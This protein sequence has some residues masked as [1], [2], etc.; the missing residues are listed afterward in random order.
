[1]KPA[2]LTRQR[3]VRAALELFTTKGFHLT[4]TP[5]IARKAGVSEGTIYRHFTGKR[6]LLNELY[7]ASGRWALKLVQD[8]AAERRAARDTLEAVARALVGGAARD[9]AVVRILLVTP[10]GD[11]LDDKSRELGREFRS[12]LEAVIAQGK[13]DGAV[14]TGSVEVWTGVWLAVVVSAVERVAAKDWTADH[15]GVDLTLGGAWAAIK[16]DAAPATPPPG[17]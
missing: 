17:A 11:L 16:N 13:A 2:D 7:R 1:M 12:A 5:L 4:T 8:A 3:L 14:R 6:H 10:H 15:A 9:P